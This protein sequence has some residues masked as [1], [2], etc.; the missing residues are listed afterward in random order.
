M[1]SSPDPRTLVLRDLDAGLVQEAPRRG[2]LRAGGWTRLGSGDVV[3]DVVTE[4]LLSDL[5]ARAEAAARAQGYAAGWAEGRRAAAEAAAQVTCEVAAERARTARAQDEEHARVVAA[6]T[7]AA[8]D[9]ARAAEPTVR[10]VEDR[11]VEVALAVAEAVVGAELSTVDHAA[12]LA[13]RRALDLV[14]AGST[15][16]LRLHPDAVATLDVDALAADGVQVAP[17]RTLGVADAVAEDDDVVVDAT[18]TAALA[19][20]REALA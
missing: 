14:P 15:V 6:L 4:S 20:V 13:V 16:R 3:G 5:A 11:A 12:R 7:A 8:V 2:E 9:A 18:I 19:R 10:A 1:S 17:D